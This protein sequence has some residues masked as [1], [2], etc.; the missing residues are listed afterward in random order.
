MSINLN[1]ST[2]NIRDNRLGAITSYHGDAQTLIEQS[3]TKSAE[4][5]TRSYSQCSDC[6]QGCAE[7]L[8][9]HI[10]GA[11]VVTHAPIGCNA[12]VSAQNLTARAVSVARGL[13]IHNVQMISTNIGE[14][15]TVYGGLEKL[16]HTIKKAYDRFNPT[17]IF[18]TSSC[19]SAIVGDDIDSVADEMEEEL[20]IPVIPVY[21][22][23]FKSRVW[24]T[25]FDAAY[26]A[27]L[28][29]LVKS[30]KKKQEDLVNIFNFQGTSSFTGL[31]EKVNLRA[32]YLVP[33]ATVEQLSEMSE[34]AVSVHMCET[35]GTYISTA[36]EEKYGVPEV[37]A[38]APFGVDW[39]DKWLRAIG[40]ET[41]RSE[42]VEKVI[43]EEHERI[44]PELELLREKLKGVRVYVFA[45]DSF[46][47]SLA[48]LA[49]DLGMELIGLTTL[50]HDQVI[51]NPKGDELVTLK[52]LVES[53]GNI[54]EFSVCNKQ[55]Y[56]VIKIWKRLKPDLLL[57]RHGGL[58]IL[59]EKLG[60]PTINE[61]DGN[62]SVGYDGVIKLGYRILEA[63]ETSQF[64]KTVAKHAKFPY[65]RWWLE[66]EP[67]P[68]YFEREVTQ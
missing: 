25:G 14:K 52:N 49:I 42:L 38:P 19:A 45:G 30:P 13:E 35:L 54:Q 2:V 20:G 11:A 47:H 18:V 46:A 36:L 62:A 68:F 8:V 37:K 3:K 15:D 24:T 59:G 4:V 61:G 7:T 41:N 33:L 31:L 27:I 56:E 66:E 39:T 44:W 65:S 1:S 51:D 28:R 10:R 55:P 16:R 60:I 48:N 67:D 26:H 34:A 43:A 5:C 50:H 63:L 40:K 17:A 23:G 22:E 9:Y 58:T 53:R 29:R 64:E 21:C 32:N 12:P 6:S 57:V